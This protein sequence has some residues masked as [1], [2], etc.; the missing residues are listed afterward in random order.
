MSDAFHLPGQRSLAHRFRRSFIYGLL[1]LYAFYSLLPLLVMVSNSLRTIEEIKSG[2]M[3][4]LP[5]A[6][7]LDA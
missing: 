4:A 1:I 5:A 3:L 7:T 6:P 2:S